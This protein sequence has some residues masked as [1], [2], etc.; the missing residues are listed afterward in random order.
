M[1]KYL[2]KAGLAVLFLSAV[3]SGVDKVQAQVVCPAGSE[4]SWISTTDVTRFGVK[5]SASAQG[6]W[7]DQVTK[8]KLC[9]LSGYETNPG[10][11]WAITQAKWNSCNTEYHVDWR[12]AWDSH[13]CGGDSYLSS[14]YCVRAVVPPAEP[15]VSISVDPAAVQPFNKTT[16]TWSSQNTTSCTASGD[17]SGTKATSGNE[18]SST[19]IF[20]GKT[21]SITCTGP[22]GTASGEAKTS[23]YIVPSAPTVAW[24]VNPANADSGVSYSIEATGSDSDG[25]LS[26]VIIKKSGSIFASAGAG[27]GNDSRASGQS[28]DTGPTTVTFTTQAT[29]AGGRT[30]REISHTVT[31]AAPTVTPLIPFNGTTQPTGTGPGV[32]ITPLVPF[33]GVTVPTGTGPT[34]SLTPITASVSASPNCIAPGGTISVSGSA[35]G[36]ILNG[37][38]QTITSNVLEKDSNKDGVFGGIVSRPDAGSNSSTVSVPASETSN[39]YDF[40]TVVNGGVYS[41]VASVAID[42][43]CGAPTGICA[44]LP[45]LCGTPTTPTV[46]T[47]PVSPSVSLSASPSCIQPGSTAMLRSTAGGNITSHNIERDSNQ[48]GVYGGLTSFGG[49]AGTQTYSTSLTE[50]LYDFRS[51]VNGNVYSSPVRVNVSAL[52]APVIPSNPGFPSS[53]FDPGGGGGGPVI[54]VCTGGKSWNGSSCVCPG[55]TIDVG[56]FCATPSFTLSANPSTVKVR[57]VAGYS[58]ATEGVINLSVNP[59]YFTAPVS[60]DVSSIPADLKPEFSFNNGPFSSVVQSPFTLNSGGLQYLPVRVRF[61]AKLSNGTTY[62]ITFRAIGVDSRVGTIVQTTTVNLD[63][64]PLFPGYVEI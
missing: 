28:V 9:Q 63:S 13:K 32:T 7:N 23:L 2:L 50:G 4:C 33:N 47:L 42:S 24:V 27:D 3:V 15:T 55:S 10:Y 18:E 5:A 21:F 41:S 62:A 19:H 11:T 61:G 54:P 38:Q 43:S 60:I 45:A 49:G 14:V 12:G 29:D 31:I 26:S 6:F 57:S 20:G 22:G 35:S 64:R 16:I 52:C 46:P 58:G 44:F 1:K 48:D 59:S 25:D 37:S 34:V 40:R 8:D 51:V 39:R 56:A 17:W 36:G 53:S 30:S